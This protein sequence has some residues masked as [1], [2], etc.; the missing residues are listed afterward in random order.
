MEF[1]FSEQQVRLQDLP[2]TKRYLYA[3]I[4][5]TSRCV[6][7]LGARGTG[8]TTM[9]LQYLSQYRH[10]ADKALYVSVD[11]PSFQTLSLVEFGKEF[12][13]YGGSALLLDEVHKYENWAGHIK[14][15]YDAC[16]GLQIIFSGSS[17]LQIHDQ[18]TDLSRRAV[19]YHLHG[20]SFRE[21]LFF[22][23]RQLFPVFTLDDIVKNHIDQ[24]RQVREKI[25]PLEHFRNYLRYGYYPYFLEGR[26]L[27]TLKLGNV[28]NRVLETDLPMA[29]QVDSRQINKLKKLL[30]FLTVNVPSQVN[31]Q[32]LASMT[33]ISRP[34][35]YD[36]I[37]RLHQ[38][39]L[40]NLVRGGES[41]YKIMSKPDKIYLENSNLS[42]ALSE[43]VNTGTIREMFF[44]NQVKNALTLHP[45]SNKSPVCT[46][47]QGDFR[48]NEKFVFEIGGKDRGGKQIRGV[49]G[50]FIASD[51]IESGFRRKIPLWL[52]GFMY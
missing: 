44:V 48:V 8:K 36:Y 10:G 37:E 29:G 35:V 5:W 1:W 31:I 41:G 3:S 46:A 20:L 33:E 23:C 27:Y 30:S 16:P 28:I 26:E 24:A 21:F 38:A 25:K 49:E 39:R 34:K 50:A 15:L 40:L 6:G 32:K 19:L 7:I 52:F 9:M 2:D 11:H 13:A 22:E 47:A 42:Y 14:A 18:D 43:R 17:I 45:A 4:A 12:F 51:E